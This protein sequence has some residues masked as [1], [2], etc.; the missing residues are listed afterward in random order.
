[1][2]VVT[3]PAVQSSPSTVIVNDDTPGL[4]MREYY[5]PRVLQESRAGSSPIYLIAEKDGV[6]RAVWAYWVEG[7][8]LRWINLQKQQ[9]QMPLDRLDRA[10]TEQLNR[11]RGV[12]FRIPAPR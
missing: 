4:R 1:V 3:V 8:T 7:A 5:G 6:I 12:D 11:E 2:T 9:G 10:L